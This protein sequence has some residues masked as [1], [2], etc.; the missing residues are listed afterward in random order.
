MWMCIAIIAL[1]SEQQYL[2]RLDGLALHQR[3]E[4]AYVLYGVITLLLGLLIDHHADTSTS[5]VIGSTI[6]SAAFFGAAFPLRRE[7]LAWTAGAAFLL[8]YAAVF[9][10]RMAGGLGVALLVAASVHEAALNTRDVRTYL[11]ILGFAAP[12]VLW[13]VVERALVRFAPRM[14]IVGRLEPVSGA[15]A[16]IATALLVL[17]LY[18]LPQLAEFYLT[19]SWSV[20]AVALFGVAIATRDKLYRW[21]GLSVLGLAF[22]R[23]GFIDTRQLEAVSRIFA[24]GGL[25]FIALALGYG[26]SR[27]FAKSEATPP[28]K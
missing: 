10:S 20:L 16:A 6:A 28:E 24:L 8:V 5:V 25:G 2:S 12:A 22:M 4:A 1:A 13:I 23:A 18:R 17:M 3:R 19:I 15:M 27:V 7:A 11:I 21:C 9:A 26:Y 14:K